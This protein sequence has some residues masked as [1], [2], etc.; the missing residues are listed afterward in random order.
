M[1]AYKVTTGG[2]FAP[3]ATLVDEG[4]DLNSMVTYFSKA[5]GDAAAEL[6]GKHGRK[7]E[8]LESSDIIDLC[9][10]RRDLKTRGGFEVAKDYT[11]IYER[12]GQR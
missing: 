9:D 1:S 7:K 5:V 8:P 2:G 12:L 3:L 4:A 6:L 11:A 10:Q